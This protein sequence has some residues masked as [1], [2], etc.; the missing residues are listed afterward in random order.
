MNYNP[1]KNHEGYNDPTTYAAM[2]KIEAENKRFYDLLDVLYTTCAL[3]GFEI[4]DRIVLKDKK[5]G[6]IWR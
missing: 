4:L 6:K 1:K 3:S 5:T 2:K